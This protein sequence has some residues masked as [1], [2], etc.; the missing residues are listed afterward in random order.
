MRKPCLILKD[1]K[2]NV[3]NYSIRSGDVT[4]IKDLNTVLKFSGYPRYGYFYKHVNSSLHFVPKVVVE[5]GG[6]P[7]DYFAGG[8]VSYWDYFEVQEDDGEKDTNA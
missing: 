4:R 8:L 6:T 7:E 2:G 1:T 5:T 3:N